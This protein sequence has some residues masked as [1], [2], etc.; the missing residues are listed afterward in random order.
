MAH[1]R[2]G[3]GNTQE[4]SGASRNA[5]KQESDS[6]KQKNGAMSKGHNTGAKLSELPEPNL[7]QFEQQRQ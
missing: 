1:S 4:K 3:P 7:E 5:R 2:A 6:N